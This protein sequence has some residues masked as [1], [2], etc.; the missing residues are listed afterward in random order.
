MACFGSP[1]ST[2]VAGSATVEEGR[3]EDVPL[4]GVGV[5]ELVDEHHPEALAQA[6]DDGR[7]VGSR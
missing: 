2:T 6:A 4:D 7:A 3:A 1:T 5:L